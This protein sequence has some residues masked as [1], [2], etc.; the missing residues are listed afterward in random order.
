[1]RGLRRRKRNTIAWENRLSLWGYGAAGLKRAVR[2]EV[3]HFVAQ[4]THKKTLTRLAKAWVSTRAQ[5]PE[6]RFF[7]GG[8][9]ESSRCKGGMR[10]E[11]DPFLRPQVRI[12]HQSVQQASGPSRRPRPRKGG[13]V[14][15]AA[16]GQPDSSKTG[17]SLP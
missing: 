1:M 11:V 14:G 5:P 3:N 12:H 2:G 16:D 13:R 17:G 4:N 10:A 15:A 9:D 7:L 6:A 8:G